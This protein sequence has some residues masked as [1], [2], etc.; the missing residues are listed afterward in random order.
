MVEKQLIGLY[1]NMYHVMRTE[2]LGAL[3]DIDE[4]QTCGHL[5]N[6][7]LL[8]ILVVSPSNFLISTT[9]LY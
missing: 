8:S 2:A 6:K 9:V 7:L 1:S 5:K 3:N 4:L